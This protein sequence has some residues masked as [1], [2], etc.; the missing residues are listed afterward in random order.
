MLKKSKGFLMG[1][2]VA[3]LLF[4]GI[5]AATGTTQNISVIFRDIRLVING[6]QITPRDAQ[7]NVV[8]PFILDGT[9]FLPVRAVAEALGQEVSWDD[10]TSTV[11]IWQPEP[12]PPPEPEDRPFLQTVPPYERRN[13]STLDTVNLAGTMFTNAIASSGAGG[14]AGSRFQMHNLNGEFTTLSG[15][16]G[17]IDG[18]NRNSGTIVFTGDGRILESFDIG[19]DDMPREI[20]VDVTGVRQLRID[21]VPAGRTPLDYGRFAFANAMIR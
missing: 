13:M 17:R 7:G 9:T 1:F 20:S 2:L 6:E 5:A 21:I 4:G 18:S 12:P 16:I 3:I 19:V 15:T 11:H 14:G 8:E 10:A